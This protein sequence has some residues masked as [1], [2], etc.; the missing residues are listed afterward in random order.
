[1][2]FG[3]PGLRMSVNQFAL[4]Q[5]ES[6]KS[7]LKIQG[8]KSSKDLRRSSSP[9]FGGVRFSNNFKDVVLSRES[10]DETDDLAQESRNSRNNSKI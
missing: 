2:S 9:K 8:N 4:A 6:H 5:Q 1:M 10:M 3:S 7:I